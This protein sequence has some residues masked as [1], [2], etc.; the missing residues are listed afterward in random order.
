MRET[1][2]HQDE[3]Y[4]F[5]QNYF[6]IENKNNNIESRKTHASYDIQSVS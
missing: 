2:L 3:K 6:G 4:D 1:K 5:V